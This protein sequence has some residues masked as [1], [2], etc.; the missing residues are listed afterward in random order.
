MTLEVY[1]RRAVSVPLLDELL[2]QFDQRVGVLQQRV[3]HGLCLLP[4][5]MLRDPVNAKADALS[6]AEEYEA[7]LPGGC[8]LRT[9]RAELDTWHSALA[10]LPAVDHPKSLTDCAKLASEVFC[11]GF[12]ALLVLLATLPVTTCTCERSVSSLRRLKTYLRSTMGGDRLT[13]LAL[14][15]THYAM[16][17]KREEVLKRFFRKTPRRVLSSYA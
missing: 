4:D 1:Y 11:V 3:I 2:G 6:F 13:G 17:I 5:A 15:H 16:D 9:V 8:I 7:D 12:S 14:L 10:K